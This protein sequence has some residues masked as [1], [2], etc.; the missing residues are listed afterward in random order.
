MISVDGFRA[1]LARFPS[2]VTVVTAR[3]E[4]EGSHGLTVSAFCSVSAEPPLVLVCLARSARTLPAIRESGRFAV[5][6]LRQH[7]DDV[8]RLFATTA[9]DKVKGGWGALTRDG[10]PV[11]PDALFSLEC[12]VHSV[13]T[14]GDHEVVIGAVQA[15]SVRDGAPLIYYRRAFHP[16]ATVFPG[17][18][19]GDPSIPRD[20][21][22]PGEAGEF[23]GGNA[24][25]SRA[26]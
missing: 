17:G 16:L 26:S 19:P 2:G 15:Y 6:M 7:H 18:R 13:L 1:A 10:P 5:S 14:A 21:A 22:R 3:G 4:R 12:T 24:H 23:R 20:D 8:A 11:V 9:L 25:R